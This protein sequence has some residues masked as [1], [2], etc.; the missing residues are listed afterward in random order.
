M[1]RLR[2]ALVLGATL[3]IMLAGSASATEFEPYTVTVMWNMPVAGDPPT[4]P[5][6]YIKQAEGNQLGEMSLK[7]VCGR[8]QEDVYLIDSQKDEDLL[9]SLIENGLPSPKDAPLFKGEDFSPKWGFYEGKD[10]APPP[11]P[12]TFEVTCETVT[13][14]GLTEGWQF[15][16]EPGDQLFGN[17]KNEVKPGDYTYGLRYN[18][19]DIDS[20]K[21]TVEQCATP[22]AT[23]TS[24]PT[25][26]HHVNVTP[27]PTSTALIV[28]PTEP[29][30]G[31][32][33]VILG[34]FG[35][36]G[37]ALTLRRLSRIR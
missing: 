17:G 3:A 15:I 36:M 11:T 19:D 10:C 18:G 12:P 27:P 20:G 8:V 37:G 13:V 6:T 30:S 2:V 7:G 5:Q 4:W 9:A 14:D 23:P 32:R 35:I 21:F 16:V 25:P 34:L 24:K 26:T 31:M 1:K 29:D 28:E 33:W 22:T